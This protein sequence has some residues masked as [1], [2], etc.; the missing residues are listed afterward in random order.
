LTAN[1]KLI[2]SKRKTPRQKPRA[3]AAEFRF[4]QATTQKR[5]ASFPKTKGIL[6]ENDALPFGKRSASFSETTAVVFR[7]DCGRFQKR[8]RSF[9]KTT[10]VVPPLLREQENLRG[11]NSAEQRGFFRPAGRMG[12]GTF[13]H[14]RTYLYVYCVREWRVWGEKVEKSLA[15]RRKVAI[16]A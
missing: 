15:F 3:S 8:L 12:W 2:D 14:A 6:S 7:N 13:A 11:E 16:F 10:A 9:C 5:R 1:P 4:R